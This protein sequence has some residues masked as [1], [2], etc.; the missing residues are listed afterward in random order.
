M[1]GLFLSFFENVLEKDDHGRCSC[2]D[3]DAT[4]VWQLQEGCGA[5]TTVKNT[6]GHTA[7]DKK[8]KEMARITEEKKDKKCQRF[9]RSK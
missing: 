5:S 6:A 2:S 9:T 7:M 4:P 3:G 8:D 1:G